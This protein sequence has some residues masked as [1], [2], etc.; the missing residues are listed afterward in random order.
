MNDNCVASSPLNV[1]SSLPICESINSLSFIDDVHIV[2]M[3]I[4]VD[5]IDDQIYFSSKINL[6]PPSVEAYMLNESTSSCVIGVDQPIC[7]NCP[8]LD[9]CMM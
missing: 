2:S 4:L 6:C 3:D 7:E 5:L 1:S 8:P 9:M